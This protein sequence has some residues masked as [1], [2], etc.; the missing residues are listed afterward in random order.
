MAR[1]RYKVVH[2][3]TRLELG[4]AQQNTLYCVGHHDRALF[5]VELI[6][7]AGGVLDTEARATADVD[8]RLV[9]WLRHA[10]S[11]RHD[12][13]AIDR[14]RRRFVETG[15]DVVHTHSSK[16]G[17]LGR[18]AAFLAGVPVVVHT[19]HG[20]SFNATQPAP[21]RALYVSLERLAARATHVLVAVSRR[22][23]EA[24]L[25]LGIGRPEQYELLRSG[26]DLESFRT[27]GVDREAARASLG[28]G[29]AHRVV[30]SVAC[31]KP[32]KAPLD[33]VRAAAEAHARE[34][35]L[36]FFLAGDGEL[37]PAV[38]A[39]IARLGLEGI[40]QLLGWRRD[41][42]QLLAAMDVFLLTSLHEG[43]PRAVLQAMAAGV[44]VVAT[45]VDGTPEVVE[46][47]VTGWLVPPARPAAA[48][49][50]VLAA[51]SDVPQRQ[52]VVDEAGRRLTRDF[53]IA[54]MVRRLD[55]L[56]LR[57]LERRASRGVRRPQH[58]SL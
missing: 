37:R 15:A 4:G 25:G 55:R 53:D 48:G 3:I 54:E 12:L 38:E 32:Q 27:A 43:L 30:G 36:R 39:E 1:A 40:V 19:V 14:L 49:R 11:P 47:G 44:P 5:E 56:Y 13:A 17:L 31:L 20:W 29:P 35:S 18:V 45:D 7:G 28:Y 26:I 41:V 33:F 58:E 51:I 9:P 16:A 50:A 52:R 10:I 34:P 8:T 46:P 2:V 24:G 21:Q 6:A 22:N 42:P 57:Q 23:L